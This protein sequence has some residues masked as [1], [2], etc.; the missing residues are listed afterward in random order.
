MELGN[1]L[2]IFC[3]LKGEFSR[4]GQINGSNMPRFRAYHVCKLVTESILHIYMCTYVPSV[5]TLIMQNLSDNEVHIVAFGLLLCT[6]ITV[7]KL[8]T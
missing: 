1:D 4:V 2:L 6:V 5:I 3:P 8:C 7:N